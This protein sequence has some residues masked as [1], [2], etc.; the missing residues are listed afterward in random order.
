[1]IHSAHVQFTADLDGVDPTTITIRLEDAGDPLPFGGSN[2]D[3]SDREVVAEALDWSPDEWTESG[4]GDPERTPNL[5]SL[6]QTAVNRGDWDEASAVVLIFETSSGERVAES[7]EDGDVPILEI[8]FSATIA[9]RLPVCEDNPADAGDKD[10]MRADCEGRVTNTFNKLSESCLGV[11]NA[12]NR[13][14]CSLVATSF[15]DKNENDVPDEGEKQHF[16]FEHAVCHDECP[17]VA[18]DPLC[19][20]FDPAGFDECLSF[21]LAN[22][23]NQTP[24]PNPCVI[25]DECLAKVSATQTTSSPVCIAADGPGESQG[26]A[27]HLGGQQSLCEVSGFSEILVGDSQEEPK[28]DPRTGGS[29]T[30]L[31]RP[32]PGATCPVGF[33]TQLAM[34]DISFDVKFARDPKF[35]DLFQTGGAPPGAAVVGGASA[36]IVPEGAAFAVSAGRRGSDARVFSSEN[37]EPLALTVDWAARQCRL[38]G[39]VAGTVDAEGVEGVCEADEGIA[40]FSDSPDCDAVGGVCLLPEDPEPLVA[41]LDLF[42]FLTQ[43]PPTARAGDSQTV[44]CTS[45][46]GA[47]FV[48]DGSSSSDP[49]DAPGL[50]PDIRMVSW[51]LG[52]RLGEKIGSE[53]QVATSLG[54]GEAGTYLLRVID[55]AI[56]SDVDTTTILV[57]DTNPPDVFCN[58]PATITPDQVPHKNDTEKPPVAF[59]ATASDVCD[60]DVAPEILG[61]DCFAFKSN[62]NIVD[63][64]RS[65]EVDITGDT[66]T[67][68]DPGGIG[69]HIVWTL[70]AADASGNAREVECEV[71]VVKKQ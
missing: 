63:K 1:V 61:F 5:A 13:C 34:D 2:G 15:N 64:T 8:E 46:N 38:E 14:S 67:V 71:E 35:K 18:L 43:Q 44:E 56:Q 60:A 32:C 23:E 20:N 22:C 69:D 21:E 53:L 37:A 51:R 10:R 40:C 45:S 4:V 58:A 9:A 55:S 65:C 11:E 3:I 31:G 70:R 39:N 36:G 50:F 57:V 19:E 6:I 28:K 27:M 41:N 54:V 66:L 24:K 48:L 52:D 7:F 33:S 59:T 42:G 12:A 26:M 16:E 49:D 62:G 17:A 68:L 25:S 29:L 47:S 30:I